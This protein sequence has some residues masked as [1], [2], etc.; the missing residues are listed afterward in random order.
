MPDYYDGTKLLSL[1]DL[2]GNRPEIYICTANKTAGKTTFF[3]RLDFN[4]FKKKKN[5][6]MLIYRFNYELDNC[7]EKFFKDINGLF[8][9]EWSMYSIKRARGIYHE[10]F[11]RYGDDEEGESCGYAVAL[12]NVDQIKKMSHLFSDTTSMTFDEF[13]SETNHYCTDEVSKLIALHTAVARGQGKMVRYV[14]IYMIGNPVSILNPYDTAL[15]ITER[16]GEKT[17][18][19]RGHGYVMEQGFNETASKALL[20]SGFARAF[21]SED[22]YIAY[23]A[24]GVYLD[25]QKT[26]IEQP[27]GRSKYLTT[28]RCDGRE[29]A[30]RSFP[31]EGIIYCDNHPDESYP[32]KIAVTTEDHNINYVMLKANDMFLQQLRFF[33]DRGCFRFK[34]LRCKNAILKALSY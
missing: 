29:Y 2:D 28:I 32:S 12:N 9:P 6:F 26:F 33:F 8:F 5:K 22:K 14:P 15:G 1:Q 4:G 31:E 19:L 3:N 10:L 13:Q 11:A 7:A 16:L 25:D 34:D 23:S 30:V 17:R 20:S 18:F 21:S 24:Q 27:K